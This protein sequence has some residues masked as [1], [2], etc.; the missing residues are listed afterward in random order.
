MSAHK[1]WHI[2]EKKTANVKKQQQAIEI[3]GGKNFDLN[4]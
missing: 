2:N 3:L 1:R 4:Q